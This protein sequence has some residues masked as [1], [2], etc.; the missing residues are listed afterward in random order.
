MAQKSYLMVKVNHQP[1]AQ[2]LD[3]VMVK[4]FSNYSRSKIKSWIL[5]GHV[6]VNGQV[7]V[8][9]KQ[10][11]IGGETIELLLVKED[12]QYLQ[13]QNIKLNIVYE[14][15][16]IIVINKQKNIVVHSGAGHVDGTILNAL[17][18]YY[19]PIVKLPRAGIVHRLDKDTTGLMIIAKTLTAYTR[20][21][22]LLKTRN[23]TRE[24]EA[25]TIGTMT[26]GGTVAQPIARHAIKRTHMTVNCIGK[27]AVTHYRIIEHFRAHTRLR[28]R[29]ETGR[30]HQIRVHM[31][32]IN[33]PLVGDKLY[34]Y[35]KY[36]LKCTGK[37]IEI[38]KKIW[39]IFDR[40]ALHATML[41]LNHPITNIEM[42]WHAALPQDMLELVY[43]LKADMQNPL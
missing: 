10:K 37:K 4:L 33:H 20:L 32:Y 22:D 3:K 19:P 12:P 21:V 42:E 34:S 7:N 18:Y 24:Y 5:N 17:L 23:I 6:M 2:R 9:P 16:Y 41:R 43:A 14:D 28:L 15:E 31:A 1:L 35:R 30:T 26:A 39:S 13:A 38:E 27:P 36:Q 8:V 25:I 40:Q 11:I 29:L